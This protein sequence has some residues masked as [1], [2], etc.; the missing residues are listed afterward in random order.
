M[1][2]QEPITVTPNSYQLHGYDVGVSYDT[3]SITGEARLTYTRRGETF[4]FRGEQIR[5]TRTPLG[6]MVT[7]DLEAELFTLV[8]PAVKLSAATRKGEVETIAV[9]SSHPSHKAQGQL[10]TYMAMCLTGAAESV[11]F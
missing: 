2:I 4:N 11:P 1:A 10:Q 7:V 9:L 5:V 3:T 8:I 6:E